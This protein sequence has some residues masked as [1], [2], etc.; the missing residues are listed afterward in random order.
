[1]RIINCKFESRT[2]FFSSLRKDYFINSFYFYF[3]YLNIK[4]YYS[5]TMN[6]IFIFINLDRKSTYSLKHLRTNIRCGNLKFFDIHYSGIIFN[7]SKTSL[8]T[9]SLVYFFI[10]NWTIGWSK[11][12]Y[13]YNYLSKCIALDHNIL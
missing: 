13:F 3:R 4:K 2:C 5:Q 8:L 12:S 10:F 7:K 11:I 1:L 6:I 9:I